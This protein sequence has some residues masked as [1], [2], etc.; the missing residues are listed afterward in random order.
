[1]EVT[2]DFWRGKRVLVTGHTGFKGSWLCL[3]LQHFG[4]KLN[5]YALKPP[6]VPSLF[7]LAEIA[8]GMSSEEADVRD[9][10][11]LR[12]AFRRHSPEI[13]L[14]LAAQSLVRRSYA[15]PVETYS[16]NVMGTV[17]VLQAAHENGKVRVVLIVTSDKC[18]DNRESGIAFVEDAP[19]GGFDPYS[20]SKGCAELITAAY[21]RSFFFA[22]EGGSR[23]EIASARAG[24][25]V[26][27]GDWAA[28]R[29]VT[30][31]MMAFS[32]NRPLRVRNPDS[33]RPWQHVLEPLRGYLCLAE[34]M[35]SRQSSYAEAWNFGAD[36]GDEHS[37]AW[38]AG[39]LAQLWGG[40]ARWEPDRTW[41]PDE[42]RVLRLDTSKARGR[43][44]YR[45]KLAIDEALRWTVEWY[46]A[47]R[48]D[49]RSARIITE[50][51]IACYL[52]LCRA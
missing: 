47:L 33:V 5:G 45:T 13:V 20:S 44:G 12:G 32:Q 36:A 15:D 14:H 19:M 49:P 3:L 34:A 16:T 48:D 38:V 2:P 41:Q 21:R 39:R 1:M 7:A 4:A 23:T 24:N 17:N 11:S 27:G 43:L 46:L 18:Y 25:V 35:W 42:A 6:T 29:L 10:D 8:R 51:Q 52:E 37:V 22:A 26:G 9:L 40:G 30:D 28:D 31:A 50:R